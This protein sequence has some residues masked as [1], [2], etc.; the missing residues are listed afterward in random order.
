MATAVPRKPLQQPSSSKAFEMKSL[1]QRLIQSIVRGDEAGAQ[2][3]RE[4]LH[5]EQIKLRASHIAANSTLKTDSRV[6]WLG[7]N[8]EHESLEMLATPEASAYFQ[9]LEQDSKR[10]SN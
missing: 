2:S 4:Q 10:S 5:M 6:D 8:G 3:M 1:K 9:Q 7:P